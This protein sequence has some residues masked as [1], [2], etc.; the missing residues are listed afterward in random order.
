MKVV[1]GRVVHV[2]AATIHPQRADE[3][4]AAIVTAVRS[5]FATDT[6][7]G[8]AYVDV[9]VFPPGEPPV[10]LSNVCLSEYRRSGLSAYPPQ[11]AG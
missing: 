1:I 11:H 6:A 5:G 7:N 10:P 9:T 8:D 3:P 4:M 2:C